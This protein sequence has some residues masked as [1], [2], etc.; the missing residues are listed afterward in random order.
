VVRQVVN[1][2]ARRQPGRR[3]TRPGPDPGLL[4]LRGGLA[5]T[6]LF[7]ALHFVEI[8]EFIF[9]VD[10][11]PAIYALTDEPLIVFTSNVFAILG[12]RPPGPTR[13]RRRTGVQGAVEPGEQRPRQRTHGATLGSAEP[14][15]AEHRGPGRGFARRRRS[16]NFL[17]NDNDR[18]TG[19]PVFPRQARRTGITVSHG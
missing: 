13:R 2:V 19:E 6:P 14:A 8:T 4:W 16:W 3:R 18:T 1:T 10:A 5:A 17:F 11:V 15:P 9:A 7:V 12:L